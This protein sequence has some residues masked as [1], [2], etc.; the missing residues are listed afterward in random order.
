MPDIERTL[1]QEQDDYSINVEDVNYTIEIKPQNKFEIQL[2][3]QGPQ[4]YR[5][6]TGN[7]IESIIKTS[8]DGLVDT[9]TITYTDGNETTFDVTNGNGIDYISLTDTQGLIKTYTI[10]F[11]NGDTKTF[12][13]TDGTNATIVGAT[14]SITG[15]TGTPA[16]NVTMGGTSSERTFDFAFSNLKGDKGDQGDQGNPGYS[17]YA[18]VSQIP[19]GAEI[20]CTDFQHGTTQAN[21]YDGTPAAITGVTASVDNN[22]GT[23]SVSVTTGGTE[24]ARTFDFAFHN[25]KGADGQGNVDSVNGQTGDVVLTA[26]DVGALSSITSSDVTTALGYTPYDNTNPSGYIT[27]SAI[28]NLADKDLSNLSAT[29]Q[30]I[31]DN[32]FNKK[33]IN[34]YQSRYIREYGDGIVSNFSSSTYLSCYSRLSQNFVD[35]PWIII[36]KFKTGTNYDY[37]ISIADT[38]L[39]EGNGYKR[40]SN[41]NAL[42]PA[43]IMAIRNIVDTTKLNLSLSIS[44]GTTS[45]WDIFNAVSYNYLEEDTWYYAKIE[46]TGSSYEFSVSEDGTTYSTPSTVTTSS[47]IPRFY[48]IF[49]C[50]PRNNNNLWTLDFG[51]QIDFS[52][53][54]FKY[55]DTNTN[56]YV[57]WTYPVNS[58]DSL[59]NVGTNAG[60]LSYSDG[61]F[62]SRYKVYSVGTSQGSYAIWIG[63]QIPN[64][65]MDYIA[66]GI[67]NVSDNHTSS[68][69]NSLV[70]IGDV[71][72]PFTNLSSC[73]T[74]SFSNSDTYSDKHAVPFR[75]LVRAGKPYLYVQVANRDIASGIAIY[76]VNIR[77]VSSSHI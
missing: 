45:T 58:Y 63:N 47:K 3:E 44:T 50:Y 25:L 62:L 66:E 65:G 17:A 13:V 36:V 42:Y 31:I 67:L 34:L 71:A 22:V 46:F 8:S 2:N 40:D 14:A 59:D 19:G 51:E 15:T 26:S 54:S 7:G 41:D 9:Y 1:S 60:V 30:E 33:A 29:G 18:R 64:T 20:V 48:P 28:S 43:M 49:G 70:V 55:L 77:R 5:G 75:V 74:M 53:T 21:V 10:Y 56:T 69:T 12:E 38:L 24:S 72:S 76:L 27:S 52:E 35:N 4:G 16:V 68:T 57:D 73:T 32:K 61:P 23:P 11:D 39:S 6:F 37:S